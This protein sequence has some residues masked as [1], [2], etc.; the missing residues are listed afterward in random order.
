MLSL[1]PLLKR[2][3]WC[4]AINKKKVL[5]L[6]FVICYITKKKMIFGKDSKGLP[7]GGVLNWSVVC[8]EKTERRLGF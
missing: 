8:L 6:F 4:L 1:Q 3:T 7:L 2:I 5:I